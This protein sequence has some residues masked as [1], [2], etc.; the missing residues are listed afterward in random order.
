MNLRTVACLVSLLAVSTPPSHA[1][2]GARVVPQVD[3]H[4]HLLSP[5]LAKASGTELPATVELPPELRS[6]FREGAPRF[7]DAAAIADFYTEDATLVF[8]FSLEAPRPEDWVR[9]RRPISEF[10][11]GAFR[12]QPSLTPVAYGIEGSAGYITGYLSGLFR[13]YATHLSLRRGSDGVWRIAAQSLMFGGPASAR[14][15]APLTADRLLAELDAAGI[16]R[17]VVLSMAYALGSP[18]IRGSDEYAQ[19][20]AENDWTSQQVAQYPDR[21]RALCSFNPLRDYALTELDRCAKEANLRHGLKLHLANSQVDL[22][23]VEHVEQLRRVFRSANAHRMPIV[24]HVWTGRAYGRADAQVFL[25]EII[26]AAPDVPIQIAHLAGA[27]P[28]IGEG[29]KEAL[30]VLAGAV[31]SGDPRTRHLYFDVTTN[32]TFQISVDD[33]AF[34]AARLRQIG[35][36]RILYGSD[37]TAFGNATPRQGWGAFRAMLPLTEAEFKIIAE[38]VAPYMR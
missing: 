9:G 19:V 20:R 17:A 12:G 4:Q 31:E 26:P 24:V 8:S 2:T 15:P 6:R 38:N 7:N 10:L 3:H 5:T 37:M 34:I 29:P 13:H 11:A 25:N 28:G 22:K 36:Q 21:L 27:G 1:Q 35:L 32:V 16:R 18:S 30:T 33:A 14:T 23:N